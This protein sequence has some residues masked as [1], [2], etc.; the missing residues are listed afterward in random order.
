[1]I[2]NG[3][4]GVRHLAT[5]IITDLIPKAVDAYTTADLGLTMGL[6]DMVAQDYD[7]AVDVL[8]SDQNDI[9]ALFEAALGSVGDPAL[10]E[11]M[12]ATVAARPASLRVRDLSA[13][14]DTDMRVLID[15]HACVEDAEARGETWASPLNLKI[16]TFIDAHVARRAY[17]SAF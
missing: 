11:R 1:M 5:R 7:R 4:E 6:L 15:L 14:A 3:A 12:S 17:D 13:Q 10:I 8:V 2:P 16:W 9:R